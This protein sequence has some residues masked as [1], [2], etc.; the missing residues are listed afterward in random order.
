MLICGGVFHIG[1]WKTHW[2]DLANPITQSCETSSDGIQW[3]T[4]KIK[5]I[6]SGF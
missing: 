4:M 2:K 5:E 6:D 3:E 1:F